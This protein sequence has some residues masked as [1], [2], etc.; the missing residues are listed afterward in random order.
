MDVEM[1]GVHFP[2]PFILASGPP[3]A[4]GNLIKR[5]F[6]AGWGGAVTKTIVGRDAEIKNVSPR[7]AVL[8]TGKKTVAM[9]NIE[10]VTARKLD[11]W[12]ED[13]KIQ[14]TSS[15][16]ASCPCTMKKA[17]NPLLKRYRLQERICLNLT[18]RVL[19]E[20]RKK[21]LEQPSGRMQIW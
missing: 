15:L 1:C 17:G 4:D 7:I 16:Q 11:E 20:C 10:L 5:G 13:I 21:E 3:T 18:S 19:T 14:K 8:K 12:I 6:K 2:N 9:Q